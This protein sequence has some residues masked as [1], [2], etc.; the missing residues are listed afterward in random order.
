MILCDTNILIEFYKNNTNIIQEFRKTLRREYSR[1]R[2]L[3]EELSLIY[4]DLDGFKVINDTIGHKK[5][6]EILTNVAEVMRKSI[7]A[8][9]I[10]ARYGGDEFCIILPNTSLEHA[11]EMAKRLTKF[12]KRI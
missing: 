4:L 7:R 2:R 8:E 11:Q 10:A 1:A 12:L 5:G 6:D 3:G 9:D